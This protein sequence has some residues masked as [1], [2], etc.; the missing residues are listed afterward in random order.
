VSDSVD[1]LA[2]G[3]HPD[4]AELGCGGALILAARAGLRVAVADLTRGEAATGGDPEEREKER[5]QAT[6]RLGLHARPSLGLPDGAVGT[7][8]EHRL[9]VVEVLRKLRPRV[10]MAPYVEDRHPDHAAAGRLA[11]EASFLAGVARIGTGATHRIGA[12]YHYMLHAPF[13]PSFLVDVS[14]VWEAKMSAVEAY[15]SQFGAASATEIGGGQFLEMVEARATFH[16]A[17]IGVARA[18]A[19]LGVGPLGFETLPGLEPGQAQPARRYSM[20]W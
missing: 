2:I 12:L 7:A 1:L 9:A 19:F 3:A 5:L 16:G 15:R 20:F 4:D 18:E 10:L 14:E 8:A 6:K 17:M 11:R 13:S